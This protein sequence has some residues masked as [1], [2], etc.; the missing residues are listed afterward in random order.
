MKRRVYLPTA[1]VGL[2]VIILGALHGCAPAFSRADPELVSRYATP[3][4]IHFAGH[5]L[6]FLEGGT[7]GKPLILFVHG[8]PGSWDAFAGYLQ[9]PQLRREAHLIS[10]DRP[11]F[12]ASSSSGPNASFRYQAAAAGLLLERNQSQHQAL[13]VGHSL[14]GSIAYRIAVDHPTRVGGILA[15]SSALDPEVI[16]PRWYNHVGN[17]WIFNWLLP[18]PLANANVEMMPL[19][20]ELEA[21]QPSLTDL[22]IPIT[23]VQGGKD[24]LVSMSHTDFAES[25]LPKADLNVKRFVDDG[26]FIVWEQPTMIR[27]EILSL[28]EKLRR[29]TSVSGRI[30]GGKAGQR[31]SSEAAKRVAGKEHAGT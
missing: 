31:D 6:H 5:P 9:D 23:I 14:G 12:G 4:T 19:R 30:E 22:D 20:Q 3:Q 21:F 25:A 7:P 29:P 18:E 1:F 17:W 27:T 15:I 2:I 13:I 8:T 10:M 26:H 24:A 16:A 11:G 28:L